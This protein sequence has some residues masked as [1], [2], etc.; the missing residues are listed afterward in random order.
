MHALLCVYGGVSHGSLHLVPMAVHHAHGH[1]HMEPAT[2][3]AAAGGRTGLR[4]IK[5]RAQ[6]ARR[7]P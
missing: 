3:R 1:D 7:R 6:S 5:G 2:V 4:R